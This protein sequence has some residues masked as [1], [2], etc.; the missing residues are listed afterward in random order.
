MRDPARIG[1]MLPMPAATSR[2]QVAFGLVWLLPSRR[3]W[4]LFDRNATPY[5]PLPIEGKAQIFYVGLP[6]PV[7]SDLQ[8]RALR[9]LPSKPSKTVGLRLGAI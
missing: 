6:S 2:L 1:A 8:G 9:Q 4:E 7:S 3:V 5:H